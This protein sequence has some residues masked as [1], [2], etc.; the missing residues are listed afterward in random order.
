MSYNVLCETSKKIVDDRIAQLE[1]KGKTHFIF[2]VVGTGS[3]VKNA[4][5]TDSREPIRKGISGYLPEKIK[6]F[7]P[8]DRIQKSKVGLNKVDSDWVVSDTGI[9]TEIEKG[10]PIEIKDGVIAVSKEDKHKLT[11]MMFGVDNVSRPETMKQKGYVSRN[12]VKWEER[13]E[14]LY[15]KT[16][17]HEKLASDLMYYAMT[18][19][20]NATPERQEQVLRQ[21][22]LL[23]EKFA[24]FNPEGRTSSQKENDF[25]LLVRE[26]PREFIDCNVTEDTKLMGKIYT[27]MLTGALVL[28]TIN[29]EFTLFGRPFCKYEKAVVEP[30]KEKE[31]LHT[32]LV[33]KDAKGKQKN[34]WLLDKLMACSREENHPY[35]PKKEAKEEVA[36]QE[37]ELELA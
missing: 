13:D 32:F 35:L 4:I 7:D 5:A 31:W 15:D 10:A 25:A 36:A 12:I 1:R 17:N 3:V 34:K 2:H 19:S 9:R 22:T 27:T 28:D 11:C 26:F 16:L 29:A 20:R 21:V 14:F 33:E 24:K 8:Y 18:E 30:F 23:G 6:I 37:K